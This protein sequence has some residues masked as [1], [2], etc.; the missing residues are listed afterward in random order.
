MRNHLLGPHV[1]AAWFSTAGYY[2]F[3]FIHV[4]F[5]AALSPDS[6]SIEIRTGR[7]QIYDPL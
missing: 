4:I 6:E 7:S 3:S 1:K 5:R 2:K